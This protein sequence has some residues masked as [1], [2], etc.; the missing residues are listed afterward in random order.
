MGHDA[1]MS[2]LHFPRHD[3]YMRL[4]L[5]EAERAITHGMCPSEL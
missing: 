4:A 5:R 3:Y 1:H 2:D